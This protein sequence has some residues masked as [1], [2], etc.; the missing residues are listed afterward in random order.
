M[1]KLGL[2]SFAITALIG[3]AQPA[4]AGP[5]DQSEGYYFPT[6]GVYDSCG[7]VAIVRKVQRA[8][9]EEGYYTGDSSGN[10]CF[11]T[12]VAVRRYKRDKGLPIIGKVDDALLNSLGLR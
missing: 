9:Q 4:Q 8:L 3:L 7:S 2:L 10:F 6:N 12:R 11:E 5:S 1:K